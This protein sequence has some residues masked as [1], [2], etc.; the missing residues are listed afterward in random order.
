MFT[1]IELSRTADSEVY[2][3]PGPRPFTIRAKLFYGEANGEIPTF[4]SSTFGVTEPIREKQTITGLVYDYTDTYSQKETLAESQADEKSFYWDNEEQIL[5]IH[6]DHNQ[7][8]LIIPEPNFQYGVAIGLTKDTVRTI[9]GRDY[10]PLINQLDPVTYE[11]DKFNYDQ[12]NFLVNNLRLNNLAGDFNEFKDAPLYGNL[13][14]EFTGEDGDTYDDLQLRREYFVEDYDFSTKEI[15]IELQDTRKVLGTQFPTKYFNDTDYT[16][17]GDKSIGKLIPFG[18]GDLKN[19]K[20]Y[21]VNEGAL[22]GTVNP[23]FIFL[24]VLGSTTISVDVKIDDIWVPQTSGVSVVLATGLV[25]ITGAKKTSGTTHSVLDVRASVE[26]IGGTHDSSPFSYASDII[27]DLNERYLGV[28]YDTSGYDTTEW[29]EEEIYLQPIGVYF[30]KADYVYNAVKDLQSLSSVG[31]KYDTINGKRTIRVDN[32]NRTE[33]FS[34]PFID[35]FNLDDIIADSNK[36]NMYNSTLIGYNK[37]ISDGTAERKENTTYKDESFRL[38]RIYSVYDKISG[39]NSATWATN[40]AELQAEDL[41]LIRTIYEIV[42]SGE[43]YLDL[44]L[45]DIL[46]IQLDE[47]DQLAQDI[48]TLQEVLSGIDAT[49][50]GMLTAT[51]TLE[52]ELTVDATV[53]E[54]IRALFG[55]VRGQVTSVTPDYDMK[56]TTITLRARP[57]SDVWSTIYP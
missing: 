3:A 32:P 33:V 11:V 46:T 23:T 20:G 38:Y 15:I 24:E 36:T 5:T 28:P 2:F 17:I 57:V 10:L 48:T 44:K 1:V 21:C 40:R 16:S 53:I 18:Y 19:V 29:E 47:Y 42:L 45:Y 56:L 49:L 22:D 25:T 31:F 12:L 54:P 34:I 43:Q 30:D 35:V 4:W 7:E 6:L 41:H 52:S 14:Q 50:Q 37:S 39:L 13:V 55:T 8:H 9:S 27:K 51:D 26:G